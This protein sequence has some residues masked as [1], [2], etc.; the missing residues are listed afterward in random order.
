ADELPWLLS[1]SPYHHVREG[2]RYPSV[3]FSVFESDSRVDPCHARKMCA[4]LQ[5]STTGS[6]SDRPIVF[7]RETEVGH[8]T[9]SVSRMVD[10]LTDELAF[11]ASATGLDLENR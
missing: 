10:L 6:D 11:L 8:S 2:V 9:R 4:A 3:L 7:R 5:H 1:Y